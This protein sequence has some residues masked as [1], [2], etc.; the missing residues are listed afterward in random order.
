MYNSVRGESK[1]NFWDSYASKYDKQMEKSWNKFYKILIEKLI[2][3]TAETKRLLEVGTGTGI[4][5]LE[6]SNNIS[7]ITAVDLSTEMI[8]V[9]KNKQIERGADNIDFRIGNA[10]RLELEDNSFDTIIASNI[11]HLLTEPELALMEMKRLLKPEGKIIVPTFCHGETMKS[12]IISRL[13]GLSGFRV[14]NRWSAKSFENFIGQ[15]GFN[16]MN[17][18]N[19]GGLMP[20]VYLAA[21]KI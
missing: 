5:A 6:L 18:S 2:Q 21:T 11:L 3:D 13:M 15:N 7:D 4:I 1:K 8:K 19:I 14:A 12:G 20:L 9:A 17:H 16:V 10:C